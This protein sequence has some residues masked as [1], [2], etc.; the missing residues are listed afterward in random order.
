LNAPDSMV[1]AYV[2]KAGG[3]KG[4]GLSSALVYTCSSSSS[5]DG[6]RRLQQKKAM[7]QQVQLAGRHR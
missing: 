4:R 5:R 6:T 2:K 7:E 1:V 3:W